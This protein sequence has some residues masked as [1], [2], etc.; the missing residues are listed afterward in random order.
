MSSK[1][2]AQGEEELVVLE[3]TEK[4]VHIFGN[5]G[6]HVQTTKITKYKRGKYTCQQVVVSSIRGM[7][8]EDY[9]SRN[10]EGEEITVKLSS[11][12]NS[13]SRLDLLDEA[14][15]LALY[16]QKND[17]ANKK[18]TLKDSLNI[19]KAIH[20][21]E[22]GSRN[23]EC[24]IACS[25]FHYSVIKPIPTERCRIVDKSKLCFVYAYM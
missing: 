18:L 15:N 21:G 8:A 22:I 10:Y 23:T 25:L 16:M 24:P 13:H 19:L 2:E 20:N 6:S 7:R 1:R 9:I 4:K 5:D 12:Y 3:E 17:L 11:N 14:F